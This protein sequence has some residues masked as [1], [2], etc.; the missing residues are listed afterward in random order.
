[1]EVTMDCENATR[2]K[3]KESRPSQLKKHVAA[4]HS[5]N[6]LSLLQRKIT[7]ALLFFAFPHLKEKNQH[8]ISI[9]QLCQFI[10]YNSRDYA[11]IKEALRALLTTL[12]EW[13]IV[14]ENVGEEDWTASTY[15]AS[16]N[17]K[18]AVCTYEYSLRLR[19]LLSYPSVYG[20][21]NLVVQSRFKSIY[22]LVLYENCARYQGMPFTKWFDISLFKKL[23]GVPESN[24]AQ[25]SDFK[26]RVLDKAIDEVNTHSDLMITPEYEHVG[27]TVKKVRF[28]IKE[29]PKKNRLGPVVD[30]KQAE[31]QENSLYRQLLEEFSL[32]DK[33][34]TQLLAEHGPEK[35]KAKIEIIKNSKS[36]K[37]GKVPNLAG[38]LIDALRK[39]YQ[40]VVSKEP[41][42][43]Q[44]KMF[45]LKEESLKEQYQQYV[46]EQ[47]YIIFNEMNEPLRIEI[48][49][50]FHAFMQQYLVLA[51]LYEQSGISVVKKE[52]GNFIREYYPQLLS[53]IITFEQ[54]KLTSIDGK[55]G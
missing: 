6:T 25:F 31:L 13:N 35:I 55:L 4:I 37:H 10:G 50:K 32:N 14:G 34:A 38:Y 11:T 51:R 47:I 2:L 1:M 45:N 16:V 23:M 30:K 44:P 15:L 43:P 40:K 48:E 41:R 36:Y 46:N 17:I 28:L 39:D 12:I 19:E 26:K 27:R 29:R 7:N 9:G 8:Q 20:K 54:Y 18:G 42:V 5:G 52:F 33:T 49:A 21:I 3:P 22:G 53:T 24:Y